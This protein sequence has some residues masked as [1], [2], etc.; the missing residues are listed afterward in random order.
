M[1][2]QFFKY[3][4]MLAVLLLAFIQT[5]C[6][7]DDDQQPVILSVTTTEPDSESFT[8]AERG[9]MIVIVGEHLNGAG[10]V[11][12]NDQEVY[13]NPVYNTASH[14]IVTI[15]SDL[16][17][18]A[19]DSS[20][21]GEIRVVTDHG[22][23][24]YAFHI[25]APECWMTEYEVERTEQP[26]GTF[27]AQPGTP[28]TIYGKNFYDITHV[29][30]SETE[31]VT[32]GEKYE[33]TDISVNKTF[34]ELSAIL[35]STLPEEGYIIIECRTNTASLVWARSAY[36]AP[37]ITS[38]SSDMPIPG[39]EVTITGS[40]FT[41]LSGLDICGDYM[42]SIS[43]LVVSNNEDKITFV[44]PRVPAATGNGKLNV[45][46]AGGKAECDFYNYTCTFGD[47]EHTSMNFSWGAS[48][49]DVDGVVDGHPT[50]FNGKYWGINSKVNEGDNIYWWGVMIFDG[51]S[52]ALKIPDSTPIGNIEMRMECYVGG[53]VTPFG[54][55][56]F[57]SD[58]YYCQ[59]KTLTDYLTGETPK[60][61]WFTCAIPL[62]EFNKDIR[63]YKEW[64]ELGDSNHQMGI[65][66][67]GL[68]TG[69][70]VCTY[71]DNFRLV[72][73]P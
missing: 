23:A 48:P 66:A 10:A 40:N 71:F 6:K 68:E 59:G 57:D 33:M 5:A 35:P 70:Y 22:E 55:R 18:C 1:N 44:L 27:L 7:D 34:D 41:K 64:R 28:I 73:K 8:D 19:E 58:S 4:W 56:F 63:T 2:K 16:V 17:L 38:I 67:Q 61:R 11:Y 46:T 50:V 14:I 26:D 52:W 3:Y 20:L 60:G 15:P 24:A 43:D 9:Q 37:V 25:L 30:L 47:G 21:R 65:Y 45:I 51:I 72:V 54:F 53:D 29:W 13:L 62:T 42:I 39:S 12:I 49:Y 36:S 32:S 31:S 69:K